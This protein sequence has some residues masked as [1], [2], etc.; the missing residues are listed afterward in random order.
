MTISKEALGELAKRRETAL[1]TG[2]ESAND[3]GRMTA[4]Q[5]LLAL[6]DPQSF[7]E[8][9]GFARSDRPEA[10]TRSII[11][12]KGLSSGSA[13]SMGV[14]LLHSVRKSGSPAGLSVAPMPTKFATFSTMPVD[15]ACRRWRSWTRAARSWTK[16]PEPLSGSGAFT[17]PRDAF[18]GSC[19]R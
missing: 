15:V 13:I 17:S 16:A 9:R 7:Q 3:T 10:P 2:G 12:A 19:P 5:R 18:P 14:R 6:F 8:F 11:P 1:R 4:R